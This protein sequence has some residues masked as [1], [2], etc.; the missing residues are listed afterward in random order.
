MSPSPIDRPPLVLIVDD[1]RDNRELL[2]LILGFEGFLTL[3]ASS[4]EEALVIVAQQPHDLI[5]L[6]IMMPGMD[7]CEVTAK[8]KGDLATKNIPVV[9]V[10]AL[11]DRSAR[12]LAH[13]AGADDFFRKPMARAELCERVRKVLRLKTLGAGSP[14]D[15]AVSEVR[16]LIT[17]EHRGRRAS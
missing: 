1:E 7:G 6:D 10:S 16:P 8:I 5:L 14:P 2:E 12:M 4:G 3:T 17:V 11:D 13:G 9:L 15:E